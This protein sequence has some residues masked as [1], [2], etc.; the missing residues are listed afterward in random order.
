MLYEVDLGSGI[1]WGCHAGV[2]FD[3]LVNILSCT[4][5][6]HVVQLLTSSSK[7]NLPHGRFWDASARAKT[8]Y[9]ESSV[10]ESAT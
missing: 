1:T 8:L 6:T 4:S 7:K 9:V 3:V 2:G 10:E 5:P